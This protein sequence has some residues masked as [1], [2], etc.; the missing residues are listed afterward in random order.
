MSSHSFFLLNKKE[1]LL[2]R[3]GVSLAAFT[4]SSTNLCLGHLA[5][6]GQY[7]KWM[8]FHLSLPRNDFMLD[9]SGRVMF[10]KELTCDSRIFFAAM[11]ESVMT[12]ISWVSFISI[13]GVR[14]ICIA[15]SSASTDVMFI[16][17]IWG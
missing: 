12:V 1:F 7:H 15:M 2:G 17:W 14:P 13:A 9:M 10:W 6:L 4:W 5:L 3:I 8:V 11:I 16:A